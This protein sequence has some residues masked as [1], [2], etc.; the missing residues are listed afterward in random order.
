MKTREIEYAVAKHFGWRSHIIVPNVSWGLGLRHEADLLIVTGS[1]F[2][3]E[4]EIKISS[5]DLKQDQFK[6]HGHY[7]DKIA[8]LYFAIPSTLK[9]YADFI[10]DRAGILVVKT[11]GSTTP[12]V[13][14]IRAAR[15]NKAAR[16]LTSEEIS[17]LLHLGVMRVWSLKQ[18]LNQIELV[19]KAV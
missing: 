2:A 15:L 19:R 9:K 17:K 7:S 8:R 12:K 18:R 6:R 4:I 16:K 5:Q 11:D 10:P 14:I 3:W 13:E 1:G